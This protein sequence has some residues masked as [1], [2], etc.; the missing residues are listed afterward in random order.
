V[1]LNSLPVVYFISPNDSWKK[2]GSGIITP[3]LH[4]GKEMPSILFMKLKCGGV[5]GILGHNV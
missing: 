4:M 5:A 2:E 1:V 3:I